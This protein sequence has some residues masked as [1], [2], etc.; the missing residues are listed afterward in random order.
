MNVKNEVLAARFREVVELHGDDWA[1]VERGTLSNEDPAD[2]VRRFLLVES[3]IRGCEPPHWY[4]THC[5]PEDA[6]DYHTEQEYAE[7]WD[8]VELVD[9]IDGTRRTVA[10]VGITW[11]QNGVIAYGAPR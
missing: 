2:E 1:G 8:I 4:T 5:T 9:L 3:N 7:D 11:A 10:Y 6:G